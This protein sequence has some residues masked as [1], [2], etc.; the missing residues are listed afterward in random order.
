MANKSG[1]KTKPQ[2]VKPQILKGFRDYPPQEQI[3]REAMIAKVRESVELMGFLPLQTASL[4][5][6]ATLLGP[7]YNDDS[8]AELFGFEGPDE[9]DMGAA[10]RV[11]GVAG[12]LCRLPAESGAPVSPLPIRECLAESTSRGRGGSASSCSLT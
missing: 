8:L 9:V 6:A 4:E 2:R 11:Y 7:H 1:S 10:V 12:A 5:F 3:A